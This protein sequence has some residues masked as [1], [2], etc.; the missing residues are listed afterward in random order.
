MAIDESDTELV[1]DVVV[2]GGGPAGENA[3][4]YA[5]ADSDRT[6]VLIEDELVGG[7]CSYW[8]CMPSKALLG[9]GS[10]LAAA[11]ALAPAA[12][13]VDGAAPDLPALLNWRDTVTSGRRDARQ[14]R[15]ARG[16]GI[17]VLRG[18]GR[19]VG[20]RTVA[21]GDTIVRARHAVVVATGSVAQIPPVFDDVAPWTSRD[22]TS[23]VEVPERMLIVGG[24]V[25]ACEAATWLL[26][27]GVRELT[28]VVRGASLLPRMEPFVGTTVAESLMARGAELVFGA[29][30]TSVSRPDAA[31]TG[32]GRIH[33]G[34]ATVHVGDR[35]L[36]VDEILV[37]AG[38][39]PATDGLF[40]GFASMTDTRGR[41]PTDDHLGVGGSSWLYAV[42]DVNGRAPVTH[43]GKYQARVAGDVIAA[44]AQGRALDERH[45]ATSDQ[46]ALPQVVFTRPEVCAVGQTEEQARAA[47]LD[48]VA[49]ETDIAVGGSYLLGPG[50]RGHAKVV[51]DRAD[52]TIVGA[53]FV[54]PDTAELLHSA[55]IAIVGEVPL[56]RLWHAV[57]AY[58]T[59]SEVWLRLME[60][61]RG[62]SI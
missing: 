18:R 6:A 50:Y 43:M 12:A 62:V 7:E 33:G 32:Y 17:E 11:T 13:R 15:W 53:T 40:D 20:E 14:V 61:L 3:A 31:D 52:S 16:V 44:R 29:E 56:T 34:P 35:E 27:A 36:V 45:R 25:V 48:V 5:I 26:D 38:R 1:F 41:L 8:A 23:L 10:A 55:T 59:V 58:P 30:V 19:I 2:I 46:Q 57:P 54:G 9:P 37:A 51:M 21:V 4:Q 39:R 24:G 22:A 42:G 47:G 60:K 28:V 49:V